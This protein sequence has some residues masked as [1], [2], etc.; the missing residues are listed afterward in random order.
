MFK[1]KFGK[2]GSWLKSVPGKVVEA[3]KTVATAAVGAVCFTAWLPVAM[4]KFYGEI[5]K[6]FGEMAIGAVKNFFAKFKT[7]E[8]EATE[9]VEVA[10]AEA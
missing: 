4:V 7:E 6:S 2:V 3:V 8:D 1:S 5:F 10:A 9:D